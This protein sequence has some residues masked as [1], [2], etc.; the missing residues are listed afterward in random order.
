MLT[1][2]IL[3][4]SAEPYIPLSQ[5]KSGLLVEDIDCSN[6]AGW[7]WKHN[8]WAIIEGD[9]HYSHH[10]SKVPQK[11]Y[12]MYYQGNLDLL[13]YKK[14]AIVGSRMATSYGKQ[15]MKDLFEE[16][17][18]KD[19]VTVSW[20]AEGIDEQCHRLS[21][22]KE[23]PTICILWWGLA[24]YLSHARRELFEDIVAHGGLLL[25]E[26]RLKEK[27]APYTF[28]QRNRI[29][30]WL[31][32]RLFVPCAALDSGSLITVADAKKSKVPV[33]G[34]PWSLYETG[35]Q[36]VNKSIADGDMHAVYNVARFVDS[37][38]LGQKNKD[39]QIPKDIFLT[40][41]QKLV[42]DYLQSWVSGIIE[43]ISDAIM[44]DPLTVSMT[45]TELEIEW[46]VYEKIPWVREAK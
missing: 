10:W 4:Y 6:I 3:R 2:Q 31:S 13:Y 9:Q 23:I 20:W 45:L 15:I 18:G 19:I 12:I 42:Y 39:T 11:P 35:Q 26:F 43:N 8:I 44:S 32:D 29:I 37:L 22:E 30:A 36:W 7:M 38:W 27:P 40:E 1:Y 41:T 16:L 24:Y 46:L 25:S 33:Y 21:I 5:L 34:T 17:A 14:L 28:P